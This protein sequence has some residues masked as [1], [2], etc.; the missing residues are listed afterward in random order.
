MS[1][2]RTGIGRKLRFEVFKRDKFTCQYC[3]RSAPD[4]VLQVDHVEPVAEGGT[5]DILNLVTSCVDCN[6]GKGA[7]R[8][9]D[10]AVVR[11]E[12]H[13][14]DLLSERREQL[15]MMIQWRKELSELDE[16]TASYVESCLQEK[17]GYSL[18]DTG[19]RKLRQ[20]LHSFSLGEV[21]DAIETAVSMVGKYDSCGRMTKDSAEKVFQMIPHV[22]K[23]NRKGDLASELGTDSIYYVAGILHNRFQFPKKQFLPRLRQAKQYGIDPK[24]LKRI[25]L[26][27]K[28][29]RTWRFTI[30]ELIETA[31]VR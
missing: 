7:R 25:A 26:S 30:E 14:L 29:Y 15:E 8:L 10:D 4:V 19:K 1:N 17:T 3:G 11:K 6:S 5:N 22:C 16:K 24:E 31:T 21:I 23:H 13:Q 18:T 12:K 28:N 9:S 20:L 27:A 2:K